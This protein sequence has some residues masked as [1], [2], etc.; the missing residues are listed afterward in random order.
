MLGYRG[1]N[2]IH[3]SSEALNCSVSLDHAS[4]SPSRPENILSYTCPCIGKGIKVY[5]PS[6][7]T[8]TKVG[9]QTDRESGTRFSLCACCIL[10]FLIISN[11]TNKPISK[12]FAVVKA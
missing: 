4:S 7:I 12:M 9:A 2:D 6:G 3:C 1:R 10:F 5:L 8:G 11:G